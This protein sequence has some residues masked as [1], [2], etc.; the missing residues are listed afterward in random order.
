MEFN[1]ERLQE[2]ERYLGAVENAVYTMIE[3]LK[4]EKTEK[5]LDMLGMLSEGIEWLLTIFKLTEEIQIEKIE[6]S[7]VV[8]TIATLLEGIEAKDWNLITDCLEYSLLVQ[9]REWQRV[10]RITLDDYNIPSL[11]NETV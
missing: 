9:V 10:V 3:D 5:T 1:L 7:E 8:D 6:T 2:A 11:E 4:A